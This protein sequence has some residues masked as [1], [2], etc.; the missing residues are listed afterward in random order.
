MNK[1]YIF[2]L[3]DHADGNAYVKE[4]LRADCEF[5]AISSAIKSLLVHDHVCI[6]SNEILYQ[7]PLSQIT[8]KDLLPY[9]LMLS[10]GKYFPLDK[11]VNKL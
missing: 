7:T 5:D 2:I 6:T 8:A 9:S 1:F 10:A 11:I 4:L 3:D